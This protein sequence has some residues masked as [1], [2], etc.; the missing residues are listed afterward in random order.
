MYKAP[1]CVANHVLRNFKSL[2]AGRNQVL[3]HILLYVLYLIILSYIALKD[4]GSPKYN[5]VSISTKPLDAIEVWGYSD[6]GSYL[7]AGYSLATDGSISEEHR[8]MKAFWPP[9][10]MV[11]D[12]VSIMVMGVEGQFILFLVL[13]HVVLWSVALFLVTLVLRRVLPGTLAIIIVLITL[14]TD[15]FQNYLLG[16]AV[17]YSDSATAALLVICLAAIILSVQ[18]QD[19]MIWIFLSAVSLAA[20]AHFRG[21]YFL[22]IQGLTF[23]ALFM[24]VLLVV[25]AVLKQLDSTKLFNQ[26][27]KFKDVRLIVLGL[28]SFSLCLPNLIA[29]ERQ[30]GDVT[31]DTA[32]KFHWTNTEAFAMMGNWIYEK[33]HA[34]FVAAGGGGTACKVKPVKCLEVNTAEMNSEQP[35][36]ILD[37]EP[38]SARDFQKLTRDIFVTNPLKWAKIKLPYFFKFWYS[39]P[40]VTS[41]VGSQRIMGTWTLIGL[42]IVLLTAAKHFLLSHQYRV[43]AILIFTIV[44]ATLLPPYLAH[45]E[46]RYL[47]LTKLIGFL[48]SSVVAGYSFVWVWNWFKSHR[49]KLLS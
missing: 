4:G 3:G 12:A 45:Y 33:D 46:T 14:W 7:R 25:M 30:L 24:V 37:N 9:G 40:S 43:S 13:V 27:A 22:V 32:G 42:V 21:Q 10:N 39:E 6:S 16:V 5:G 29:R 31:W 44:L 38:Y 1:A 18:K 47:V 20:A 34:G 23:L 15:L 28:V 49:T 35:F 48:S 26:I 2:T 36:S 17:V 19:S 11:L 41:A 8:W